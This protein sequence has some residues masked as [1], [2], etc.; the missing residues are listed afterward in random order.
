MRVKRIS[1]IILLFV[2]ICL[3]VLSWKIYNPITF[4][5][6][7][8]NNGYI[9]LDSKAERYVY[10]SILK[11]SINN[12][13]NYNYG[14]H[15]IYTLGSISETELENVH[16]AI[17]KDYPYMVVTYGTDGAW[18]KWNTLK[19]VKIPLFT[20]F[21]FSILK[22]NTQDIDTYNYAHT[23]SSVEHSEPLEL[24]SYSV[25]NEQQKLLY[26]I[27]YNAC[28]NWLEVV[29]VSTN[30]EDLAIVCKAIE[31][32]HPELFWIDYTWLYSK[33]DDN[34]VVKIILKYKYDIDIVEQYQEQIDKNIEPLLK[35]CENFTTDYE[36]ALHIYEWLVTNITYDK[37]NTED[38]QNIISALINKNTVCAGY[39]TAYNYILH[40]VNIPSTMVTGTHDKDN[41]AWNIIKINDKY[42]YVDVTGGDT[43][44]NSIGEVVYHYFMFDTQDAYSDKYV[45]NNL[46]NTLVEK[47]KKDGYFIRNGAYFDNVTEDI[48]ASYIINSVISKDCVS[49]QFKNQSDYNDIVEFLRN[50]HIYNYTY[51]TD[52]IPNGYH[53][54][55]VDN[56]KTII[57]YLGE[58]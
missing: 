32:D 2:G 55:I 25:L 8:T 38:K 10:R 37:E 4:D 27:I 16:K 56:F 20:N 41:H 11:Q 9:N 36:K 48:V 40:K 39:T 49:I 6:Y 31:A 30:E 29:N 28:C 5:K 43:Y 14:L 47:N 21:E 45:S 33:L 53:Y 57:F 19:F 58:V 15:N 46:V 22:N 50:G 23:I 18:I 7:Q 1:G 35:D 3:L 51:S 52:Y 44:D 54:T 42:Y 24:I 34:T 12:S 13:N 17:S 26:D